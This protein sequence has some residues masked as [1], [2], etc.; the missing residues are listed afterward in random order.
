MSEVEPATEPAAFNP[1]AAVELDFGRFLARRREQL[2]ERSVAPEVAD[3][4][5]GMDRVLRQKIA[6]FGPARK[7]ARTL[8]YHVTP[9]QR[10]L[11]LM[12]GVAVGPRQFPE[13][14]AIGQECAGRLGVG[15]PQIFIVPSSH[16][17][18]YTFATDDVAPMVVLSSELVEA[19]EPDELTFVVGHE[20]GHI[21]NLHGTYN[22][23]VQSL[24]NPL[25]KAL[26][27]KLAGLGTALKWI[28][29]PSQIKLLSFAVGGSIH[30]FL[31][32]WSRCAEVTCD[33]A[34]LICCGDLRTAQLA[35]ARIGTGGVTRLK[36]V[37]IEEYIRQIESV[38][39]S[40]L[41]FGELF[42]SHPLIPKRLEALR[43]FA[44]C[45]V[46]HRWRPEVEVP[47]PPRTLDEVDEA[48]QGT[49]GILSSNGDD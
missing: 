8:V 32:R 35:L 25:A 9:I 38:R 23:L 14:H 1:T 41:R 2:S 44:E 29:S 22:S 43:L 33:R 40:V 12:G 36:G 31:M 5:F 39:S 7:I 26:T 48:C 15:V 49:L 42:H 27:E 11:H 17:D 10:Q 45:E 47:A 30:L 20:C 6:T 16:L 4:A 37:N 46:F 24:V 34:G 3:Y 18:A 19:L 13:I 21:A 28:T